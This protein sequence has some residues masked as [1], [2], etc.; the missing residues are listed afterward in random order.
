MP[1]RSS[2]AH[3]HLRLGL[4]W[5]VVFA[6]AGLVLESLHGL[7]LE[8][9]VDVQSQTRRHMWTLAHA[10]GTLLGLIHLAYAALLPQLDDLPA[11]CR[12]RAGARLTV[13]AVCLPGG[14]FLGG[15]W[16]YAGDP[17][18]GILLVPIGALA[19]IWACLTLLGGL[20]GRD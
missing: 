1:T 10:H 13:A 17:G 12:Q 4:W 20:R 3:H 2:L 18:L 5:V 14:F 8:L 6:A 15:L 7:K 9:Y 16:F 11:S 19:L